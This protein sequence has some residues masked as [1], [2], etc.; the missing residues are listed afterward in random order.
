MPSH[1]DPLRETLDR[2]QLTATPK[3]DRPYLMS[4]LRRLGFDVTEAQVDEILDTPGRRVVE[5]EYDRSW[6]PRTTFEIEGADL[7]DLQ[8]FKLVTPDDEV[9]EFKVVEDEEDD[10]PIE[11]TGDFAPAPDQPASDR[12]TPVA[13]QDLA[14]PSAEEDWEEADDWPEERDEPAG[15]ASGPRVEH[16]VLLEE[17][18]DEEATTDDEEVLGW[19]QDPDEEAYEDQVLGTATEAED[20][21]QEFAPWPGTEEA[22]EGLDEDTVPDLPESVTVDLY[23]GDIHPVKDIEGIGEEYESRLHA[24][25]IHDTEQLV[26]F[27]AAAIAPRIE[28]PERSVRSWQAMAEL[29]ILKGI[30]PQYAEVLAR[31]GI[32]GIDDLRQRSSKDVLVATEELLDRVR[33]TVIGQRPTLARIENWRR[34]TNEVVKERRTVALGDRGA[35]NTGA[36]WLRDQDRTPTEAD[37]GSAA[38]GAFKHGKY[39]LCTREVE[40]SAGEKERIYFFAKKVP[41]GWEASPMPEGYKVEE[42]PKTGLPHLVRAGG[43]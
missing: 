13:D 15:P 30:G 41:Q 29:A 26:A 17:T 40:L 43:A 9:F 37:S 20:A 36:P 25:G 8:E 1:S 22:T 32:A 10:R 35:I 12:P 42:N 18:E 16:G 2:L 38:E 27:D 5:V 11:D 34:A 19:P 39:T 31:A 4:M 7:E 28:A 23:R 24:I 33:S 14:V 3:E 21:E 6:T